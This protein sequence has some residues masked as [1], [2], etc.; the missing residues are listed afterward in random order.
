[1][2]NLKMKNINVMSNWDAQIQNS[3]CHSEDKGHVLKPRIWAFWDMMVC[4]LYVSAWHYEGSCH[5]PCRTAIAAKYWLFVLHCLPLG[6]KVTRLLVLSLRDTA[7]HPS[8]I[9][10]RT[11]KH[12][13][14][15]SICMCQ[16]KQCHTP[17]HCSSFNTHH[18][19]K[20][21]SQHFFKSAVIVFI[22][23]L[24]LSGN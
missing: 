9:A 10:V 5:S 4:Y 22:C 8:S 21:R 20:L 2:S 1:M 17:K 3:V 23:I 7:L 15:T 14:E 18:L 16:T 24:Y 19:Q 11:S 12:S 13:F 6:K